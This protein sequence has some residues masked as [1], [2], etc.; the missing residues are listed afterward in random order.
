MYIVKSLLYIYI[1][2]V[3]SIL[4][5]KNTEFQR[6]MGE[7]IKQNTNNIHI[8]QKRGRK[9]KQKNVKQGHKQKRD[10]KI[11]DL[12]IIKSVVT[13]NTDSLDITNGRQIVRLH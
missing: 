6:E 11:I 4:T 2:I 3:I 9:G 10:N 12:I 7:K 8:I 13:Y 5:T 1:Y